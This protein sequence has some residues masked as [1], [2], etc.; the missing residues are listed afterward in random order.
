MRPPHTARA[1][2]EG[3][4][5]GR[6]GGSRGKGGKRHRNKKHYSTPS[7]VLLSRRAVAGVLP[8]A[9]YTSP[10]RDVAKGGPSVRL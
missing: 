4:I 3:T 8:E 5:W 7:I 6:G 2:R 10:D 9:P 1:H